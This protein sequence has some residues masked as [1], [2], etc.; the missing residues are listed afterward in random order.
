MQSTIFIRILCGCGWKGMCC[1]PRGT[2]LGDDNGVAVAYMMALLARRDIVH[3]PLE[4]LFTSM[5]EIGLVGS[6]V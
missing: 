3:P 4:C 6:C 1:A 5:E 2:T